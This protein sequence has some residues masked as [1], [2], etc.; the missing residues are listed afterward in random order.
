M[1]T[2]NVRRAF[3]GL[4]FDEDPVASNAIRVP[5]K[6]IMNGAFAHAQGTAAAK[7]KSQ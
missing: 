7:G 3:A 5:L 2:A 1:A 6:T 4:D